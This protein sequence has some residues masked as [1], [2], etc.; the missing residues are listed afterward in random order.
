MR[1]SL[2]AK[3]RPLRRRMSLSLTNSGPGRKL[4]KTMTRRIRRKVQR[5]RRTTARL[6]RRARRRTTRKRLRMIL[7][8]LR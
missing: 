6:P 2:G 5:V 4:R 7:Q 3:R 1:G 8:I